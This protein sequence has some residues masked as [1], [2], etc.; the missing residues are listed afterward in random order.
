MCVIQVELCL[1]AYQTLAP[2][3]GVAILFQLTLRIERPNWHRE[4]SQ[5]ASH[6]KTIEPKNQSV[7]PENQT[8]QICPSLIKYYLLY[9]TRV[10]MEHFWINLTCLLFL[11]VMMLSIIFMSFLYAFCISAKPDLISDDLGAFERLLTYEIW[12]GVSQNVN[13]DP[14]VWVFCI[15]KCPASRQCGE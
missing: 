4:Q 15:W 2:T 11:S 10:H 13:I 6:A 5:T 7:R 3:S 14:C 1:N 8:F 12:G 9:Y